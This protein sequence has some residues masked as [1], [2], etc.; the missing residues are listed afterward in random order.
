[1]T[2]F[3]KRT[4]RTWAVAQALYCALLV[5]LVAFYVPW[6]TPWASALALAYAALHGAGAPGLWAGRR[7][8]WRLSLAAGLL[9]LLAAVVV[10]GGLVASWAYLRSIYDDF[11]RG[12]SIA[13]LMLASVALQL[14]GLFPALQ[15]RALLRR[16]VRR[17]VGAGRGLVGAALGLLL[18][19]PALGVAVGA[20]YGL[21]PLPPVSAAAREGSVALLRAALRGEP[22]GEGASGVLAGVSTGRGPLFV[23]L[24]YRGQAVA[25][26][27]GRGADLEA[28]T[29]DAAAQ[30]AARDDLGLRA[31]RGGRLRVDRVAATGPVLSEWGPVLALSVAPGLDGLRRCGAEGCRTLLPDDL[32]R[33]QRFG[34]APLVPGIEELRLGLDAAAVLPSLEA[35][36]GRLERLRTEGW[37]EAGDRVLP[38]RR[39]NTPE[40][41][42]GPEAW[43]AAALA[44]GD[45]ILRQIGPDGRFHYIYDPLT[46]RHLPGNYSIPRHAG[47]IYSLSLLYGATGEERYRRG[48]EKAIGWLVGQVPDGCGGAEG[49]CI[50]SGQAARLGPSALAAVG[51]LEYQRATGDESHAG[52]AR[53]LMDFLLFMQREDGEL[54]QVYD[55]EAGR[56]DPTARHMF[57]SEEAALAFVLAHEVLGEARYLEA[58]RRAL[59][60]L[61]GPKYGDFLG[62]FAY[63]ADHWTCIAAEEAW[64]RLRSVQYLDFCLG[65]AEFMR[66]I[67]FRPGGGANDDFRGHYGFS[68]LVVPPAP[69]GAGFTEAGVSAY[70]LSRHHGRPDEALRR[71]NARN[72]DALCRDQIRAD[73]SWL[74]PAPSRAFGGIRRSLV[75]Q[76]VRID[77]PQH[78]ASALLRG[79][80][81]EE[82]G[83]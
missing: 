39:G 33:E 63:G 26:V 36:G 10:C 59:D 76:D 40:T 69:A 46:N 21:H 61:T 14:L 22:A 56:V 79:A 52:E 1:M 18:L 27:E 2:D 16:E 5:V 55:L 28:A 17:D 7:W 78:A 68:A 77:F 53:R 70:L 45:Y 82:G 3:T 19:P 25:R 4:L 58:A 37:V 47:T 65:Y 64:P 62:H 13:A 73:N 24:W 71:Q 29:R 74:M 83:S 38:V 66:R 31:R 42:T 67:Q 32:L 12:A 20:R 35:G 41:G 49:G 60:Y 23:T 43:R 80:R 8:G 15:V 44:G 30:L 75:E 6:K 34:S 57:E 81:A 54:D 50:R 72:L 11:G 9:G 48:A 51:L